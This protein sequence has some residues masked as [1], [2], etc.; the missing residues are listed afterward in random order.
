M[1]D[2]GHIENRFLAISSGVNASLTLG[3]DLALPFSPP[4][5]PSLSL[6]TLPPP[7]PPTSPLEGE[8]WEGGGGGKVSL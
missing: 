7:L 3:D 5:L 4:L 6:P 1:A 8:R 2:G